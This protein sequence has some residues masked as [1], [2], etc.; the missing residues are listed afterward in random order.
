MKKILIL[1][2]EITNEKK[3]L[4]D[5]IAGFVSSNVEVKLDTF[6]NLTFE[7][8][9]GKVFVKISDQDIRDFNLVYIRSID[10]SLRFMVGT[11]AFCLDFFKIKYFNSRFRNVRSV[12][13]KLTSLITL[14]LSG[15][16]TMPTFFCGRER[17]ESNI[18]YLVNKYGYPIVVKEVSTHH[19]KGLFVMRNKEDFQ[20]LLKREDKKKVEQFLFQKFIPIEKEYRLLVLGNSVRSAQK[21]YRDLGGFQSYIDYDKKEEFVDVNEI[22]SE[23]KEIAVRS[24]NALNMQVA[25]VDVLMTKKD[26]EIMLIEVNSSPGFTYDT[27]ISPEILQ[28]SKFLEEEAIK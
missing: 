15:L 5:L 23:A 3:R 7:L 25:G 6:S 14:S 24:A 21:M 4:G 27:S 13:D 18:D 8:E 19:S 16:P 20:K 9:G 26:S 10:S 12:N 17:V 28:L 11:L 22:S 1:V 2:G